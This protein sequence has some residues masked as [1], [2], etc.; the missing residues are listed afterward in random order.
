VTVHRRQPAAHSRSG[1]VAV[2]VARQG[3]AEES[4]DS[5]WS[6][7]VTGSLDSCPSRWCCSRSASA[8][9]RSEQEASDLCDVDYVARP[10]TY[11]LS[12]EFPAATT[13]GCITALLTT[14]CR[15]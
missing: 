7:A 3:S 2:D 4:C 14:F 5:K 1:R 13:T 6:A 15:N 11:V 9:D 10:V 8:G 12:C